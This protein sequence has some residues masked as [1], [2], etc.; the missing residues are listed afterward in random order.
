VDVPDLLPFPVG[1]PAAPPLWAGGGVPPFAAAP[2]VAGSWPLANL[3]ALVLRTHRLTLSL[4]TWSKAAKPSAGRCK[5]IHGSLVQFIPSIWAA[6]HRK[7]WP[8]LQRTCGS[9]ISLK[10]SCEPGLALAKTFGAVRPEGLFNICGGPPP[11]PL[12]PPPPLPPPRPPPPLP[13]G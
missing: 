8:P 3:I 10:L 2:P 1:A 9:R 11:F 6:P 4:P 12:P 13:P 5:K 7:P